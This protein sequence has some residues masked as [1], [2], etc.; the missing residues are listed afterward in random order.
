MKS[1]LNSCISHLNEL[2]SQKDGE[3]MASMLSIRHADLLKPLLDDVNETQISRY[4]FAPFDELLIAH[5]KC[6]KALIIDKDPIEAFNFKCQL[7]QALNRVLTQLKDENWILPVMNVSAVEIRQL[8]SYV[9]KLKR[10]NGDS[11]VQSKPDECLE[12]AAAQIMAS[13]RICANDNRASIEVS[14]RKGMI[15]LINQLF[16]IYFKINKLHLNK[17][18]ARALE[19]ANMTKEFSLA[20]LV[21]YNYFSGMK[22]L[23][24]SDY[25]KAE[26]ALSFAF[27]NC[28]PDSHRN[29]RLILIYLIPVK[30]LLGHMP[31]EYLLS[32]YDLRQF[33]GVIEAVK[34][35]NLYH[36]DEALE[37]DSDFFWSNGIYLIL[38]KLKSIAYR[39]LFKKVSNIVGT[40]Q[41]PIQ[42]FVA[43]I[44]Y[45]QKEEIT[46]EEVHCILANLIFENKIKGYISLQHQKLVV[47]KQNAFPVLSSVTS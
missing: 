14:K 2:Q 17:P 22:S 27:D 18:L 35:G 42:I 40:H 21:T 6:C 15:N 11:S 26:E 37:S 36:F 46:V 31:T 16:K 39:N 1:A 38:E 4:V 20:Q 30:M 3:R 29:H 12:E 33:S 8:A 24:D 32:K 10:Q 41:I 47:S 7:I 5:L 44:N 43:A 28:H 45:S 25:K 34:E 19:N 13:F 9:D 23:F